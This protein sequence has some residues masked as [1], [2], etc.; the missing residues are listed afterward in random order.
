MPDADELIEVYQTVTSWI[1]EARQRG[2]TVPDE[3]LERVKQAA[4]HLGWQLTAVRRAFTE[5]EP[6]NGTRYSTFVASIPHGS[7][8]RDVLGGKLVWSLPEIAGGTTLVTDGHTDLVPSYVGGSTNLGYGD[9]VWVA[10]L[11]T[12]VHWYVRKEDL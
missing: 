4:S 2:C 8:G 7:R 11:M 1:E 3:P 12:L 5:F 10:S 9:A 6:G